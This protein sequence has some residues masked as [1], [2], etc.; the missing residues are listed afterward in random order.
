VS[1]LW[2]FIAN[3]WVYTVGVIAAAVA[4]GFTLKVFSNKQSGSSSRVDQRRAQAGGDIV[5]RDKIND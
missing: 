3:H 2:N 1:A 5:G 4:G